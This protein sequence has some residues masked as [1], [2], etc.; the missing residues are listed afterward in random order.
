MNYA[1]TLSRLEGQV[2]RLETARMDEAIERDR[3]RSEANR[4]REALVLARKRIEYYGTISDRR[5]FDHDLAK[6]FPK[7]DDALK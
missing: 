7:I 4:L 6:V 1:D 2:R 3:L 5:H